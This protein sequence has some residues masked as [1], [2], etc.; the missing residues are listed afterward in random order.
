MA[1]PSLPPKIIHTPATPQANESD[2]APTMYDQN[3]GHRMRSVDSGY[4]YRMGERMAVVDETG[5]LPGGRK[6]KE[7]DLGNGNGNG[8]AMA[9]G[10]SKAKTSHGRGAAGRSTK[11][12]SFDFERPGWSA[13]GVVQRS[14]SSGT[15]GSGTSETTSGWS[16]NPSGLGGIRESVMGPGLAGVGTLQRD[17]SLKRSKEREEMVMRVREDERI[18]R[19]QEKATKERQQRSPPTVSPLPDT[20]DSGVRTSTSTTGK[21]SSLGKKRGGFIRD[22]SLKGK[23][24]TFGVTHGRFAFEPPVSRK[25]N[26]GSTSTTEGVDAQLSVSWPGGT[27]LQKE[28]TRLKEELERERQREKAKKNNPQRDRAAVPVPVPNVGHRSATKGRS[29]DLGLGLAW[30][31]ATLKE[32]ALLPSSGFFARSV[33]G[34]SSQGM[35]R[36]VS[37]TNASGRVGEGEGKEKEKSKVGREIAD[38]FRNAL[39]D[40]GYAAFKKCMSCF[41][42]FLLPPRLFYLG[43]VVLGILDF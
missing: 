37:I 22:E 7:R 39:D 40:E 26:T 1:L 3:L 10:T 12:G 36:S 41:L 35:H 4:R 14:G 5:I 2:A 21:S 20:D 18:R 38:V 43:S 6:G 28:S 8:N 24:S 33:S 27:E 34:S 16:R 23:R 25:R 32:E 15:T 42:L 13:A 31:P 9:N 17:Q 29:L 30:A 11:H 19:E